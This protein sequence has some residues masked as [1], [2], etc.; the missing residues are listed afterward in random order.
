MSELV[1]EDGARNAVA[2]PA[3]VP[4]SGVP[5]V[6]SPDEIS[7]NQVTRFLEAVVAHSSTT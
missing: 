2:T 6:Q 7:A 1:A 4:V 3:C 5:S